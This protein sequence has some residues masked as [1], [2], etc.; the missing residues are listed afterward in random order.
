MTSDDSR[1]S[2]PDRIVEGADSAWLDVDRAFRQRLCGLVEREMNKRYQSREDAEDI[3]QSVFRTFFRRATEGEFQFEHV[4]AL[5]KLLQ[6]LARRKILKHVEYHEAEKRSPGKEQAFEGDLPEQRAPTARE[7]QLL[8]DALDLVL[9][10]VSQTEASIFRL[11]L[12]GYQIWEIV[13]R[14]LENLEPPY[15]EILALR[16]QGHTEQQIAEKLGIGREAVRYKLRRI[17]ERLAKLL[18]DD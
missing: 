7:A 12:N 5:W 2:L 13:T 16:L 11:Q 1:D 15:P 3:V 4:G 6:T 14:I 17:Q 10:N 9:Q 18:G 8:G